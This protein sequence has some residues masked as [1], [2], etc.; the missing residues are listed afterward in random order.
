MNLAQVEFRTPTGE[1]RPSPAGV[2]FGRVLAADTLI[3]A[4]PKSLSSNLATLGWLDDRLDWVKGI[5]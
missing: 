1:V 5:F 4:P 3:N 2:D